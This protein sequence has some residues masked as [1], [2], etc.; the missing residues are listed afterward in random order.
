MGRE[1]S[2]EDLKDVLLLALAAA[3]NLCLRD[4]G[5]K[6]DSALIALEKHSKPDKRDKR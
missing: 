5:I 4:V 3:D 1:I 6:I 2:P